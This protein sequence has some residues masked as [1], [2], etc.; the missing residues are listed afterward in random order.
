MACCWRR[1]GTGVETL[2]MEIHG[3]AV[4]RPALTE[5]WGA[6]GQAGAQL[7]VGI[8]VD[9]HSHLVV[10]IPQPRMEDGSWERVGPRRFAT[11][12]SGFGQLTAWLTEFGLPSAAVRIGCEPTGGWYA[13]TAWRERQGYEVAW[14][15]NWAIHDRRQLLIGKQ[16]KTDALDAC[17]SSASA[18]VRPGDF[19]TTSPR[20]VDGLRLLVRNRLKLVDLRTRYRNR[21][22]VVQEVLFPELKE[23]FRDRTPGRAARL[24]L[25]HFPTPAQ[26]AGADPARVY[27]IVVK[28]GRARRLAP[29]LSA[30][31]ER[32]AD[33]AG[34]T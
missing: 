18:W 14:L 15:Q 27:E 30:L 1:S 7:Y 31:Q 21:L 9:R 2:Y 19:S 22:M 23:F 5:N 26:L 25:E 6:P 20:P 32:A 17:S 4:P 33:S 34:L 10:A 13:R 28:Q 12:A 16:T 8:D 29:R 24:L 11:S 3:S